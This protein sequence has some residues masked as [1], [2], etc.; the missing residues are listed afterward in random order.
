MANL[1]SLDSLGQALRFVYCCEMRRIQAVT[2]DFEAKHASERRSRERVPSRDDYAFQWKASSITDENNSL[3]ENDTNK[4]WRGKFCFIFVWAIC[5]ILIGTRQTRE[6]K[7]LT[8]KISRSLFTAASPLVPCF[9]VRTYSRSLK[10]CLG[11]AC[12]KTN[13][14]DRSRHPIV[15]NLGTLMHT[16]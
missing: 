16:C 8:L 14:Q 15:T 2:L 7:Q 11:I 13:S 12:V 3:A 9:G 1:H 10:K 5:F 6:S 4:R